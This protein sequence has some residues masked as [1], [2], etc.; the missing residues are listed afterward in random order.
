M[1][2]SWSIP[3]VSPEQYFEYSRAESQ[4]IV[5][6]QQQKLGTKFAIVVALVCSLKNLL[7]LL[8]HF[9]VAFVF[10]PV[11]PFCAPEVLFLITSV[12]RIF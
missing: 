11:P 2:R 3:A 10:K 5:L 12:F 8:P 7:T 9:R 6:G 4:S 1:Y